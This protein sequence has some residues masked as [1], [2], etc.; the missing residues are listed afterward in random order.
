MQNN[1]E[2]EGIILSDQAIVQQTEVKTRP[3]KNKNKERFPIF[4]PIF[5]NMSDFKHLIALN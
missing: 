2:R 5:R 4:I 3:S 1:D